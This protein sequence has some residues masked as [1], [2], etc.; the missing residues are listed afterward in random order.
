MVNANAKREQG[1][2]RYFHIVPQGGMCA[3]DISTPPVF[4]NESW[5][6][7]KRQ[8]H[9]MR[10]SCL[11]KKKKKEKRKERKDEGV[12]GVILNILPRRTSAWR[13]KSCLDWSPLLS[14]D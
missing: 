4:A 1:R 9:H 8:T 3:R 10:F 14:K 5:S 12:E 13:G 6:L 7:I 11:V 2:I